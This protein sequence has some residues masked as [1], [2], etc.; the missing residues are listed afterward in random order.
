[1]SV[2]VR[3]SV[4]MSAR[5][6]MSMSTMAL[7]NTKPLPC[8]HR[9][10]LFVWLCLPARIHPAPLAFL[11]FLAFH[12]FWGPS[13]SPSD[14]SDAGT[15]RPARLSSRKRTGRGGMVG[16]T[17]GTAMRRAPAWWRPKAQ[18]AGTAHRARGCTVARSAAARESWAC[19][20]AAGIAGL[21]KDMEARGSAM[22]GP[23]QTHV[24]PHWIGARPY[25]MGSDPHRSSLR[26]RP[27]G[28]GLGRDGGFCGGCMRGF[29]TESTRHGGGQCTK[30]MGS[31]SL[32]EFTYS[33]FHDRDST[34]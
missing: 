31:L 21:T 20:R 3:M 10:F 27:A 18:R 6:S 4:H 28:P 34:N 14:P 5:L 26:T 24:R 2:Q 33:A 8:P 7:K 30:T 25:W 22:G 16:G 12:M 29:D 32:Q 15:R 11:Y 17:H 23:S 1:M 13:I 19:E 9:R